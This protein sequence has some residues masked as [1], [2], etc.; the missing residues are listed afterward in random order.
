MSAGP[1]FHG[2]GHSFFQPTLGPLPGWSA[3]SMTIRASR[4]QLIW[5]PVVGWVLMS[6]AASVA[7][8]QV[9]TPSPAKQTLEQQTPQLDLPD[10]T[11]SPPVPGARSDG[12]ELGI[13]LGAFTLYPEIS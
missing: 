10:A 13:S 5:S 3:S 9:E 11:T 1:N 4:V 7:H 2:S 6:C 12:N 8:A